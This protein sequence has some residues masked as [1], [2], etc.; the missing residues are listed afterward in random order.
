MWPTIFLGRPSSFPRSWAECG[1]HRPA[2][3]GVGANCSKLG[4][5][6]I[7]VS[8]SLVE[9]GLDSAEAPRKVGRYR[10]KCERSRLKLCSSQAKTGPKW[11]RGRTDSG[12]NSRSGPPN[13]NRV[14]D[15][16][17]ADP[18]RNF[19]RPNQGTDLLAHAGPEQARNLNGI[20]RTS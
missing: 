13:R 8:P 7:E 12:F 19:G 5:T 2:L 11:A 9:F 16:S 14:E 20:G 17:P 3:A 18:Q 6:R 1:R 10:A 4:P 15:Q